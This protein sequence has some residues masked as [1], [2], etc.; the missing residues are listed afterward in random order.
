MTIYYDDV[1]LIRYTYIGRRLVSLNMCSLQLR[2]F[3]HQSAA[4]CCNSHTFCRTVRGVACV[5]IICRW[6]AAQNSVRLFLQRRDLDERGWLGAALYSRV[7][8]FVVMLYDE[9][10]QYVVF[11]SVPLLFASELLPL[12]K[13]K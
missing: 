6:E 5:R 3:M 7:P 2:D 13:I 8:S 4:L 12:V 10:R 9:E 1:V 11:F